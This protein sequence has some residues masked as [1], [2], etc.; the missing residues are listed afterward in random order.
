MQRHPARQ[1]P[2]LRQNGVHPAP[3]VEVEEREPEL[4]PARNTESSFRLDELPGR[5]DQGIVP[6]DT[7]QTR[8]DVDQDGDEEVRRR[9]LVQTPRAAFETGPREGAQHAPAPAGL[10]LLPDDVV[11][12]HVLRGEHG[13]PDHLAFPAAILSLESQQV[14]GRAPQCGTGIG[15]FGVLRPAGSG[16]VEPRRHGVQKCAGQAVPGPL[17]ILPALASRLAQ[18]QSPAQEPQE[19]KGERTE[20]LQAPKR[21]KESGIST[22]AARA[23]VP[24]NVRPIPIADRSSQASIREVRSR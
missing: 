2:Q 8:R 23:T 18:L 13:A 12:Q 6:L 24:K 22:A 17:V 21:R 19:T 1:A 11:Q 14:R 5:L 20:D 15:R 16:S 4:A 3:V 7:E 9:V 10:E